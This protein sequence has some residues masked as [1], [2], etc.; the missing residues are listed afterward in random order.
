MAKHFFSVA[1]TEFG[2]GGIRAPESTSVVDHLAMPDKARSRPITL[3]IVCAVA[4]IMAIAAGTSILLFHFRDRALADGERELTNTALIL[5]EQS[6]QVFQ[7]VDMVDKSIIEQMQSRGIISSEDFERQM[8]GQDMHLMLKDKISGLP[9][10]ASVSLFNSEGN[11]INFSR[12]WPIPALNVADQDHFKALK[13]DAH[14][15]SV[16]SAPVLNQTTRTWHVYLARKITGPNGEFLGAV[17]GGLELKYFENFFGSIALGA[18]SAIALFRRDGVLLVRHPR[19]EAPGTSFA[20]GELFKNV[21]SHSDHGVVRLTSPIDGEERL[22]AGYVLAHYPVVVAVGK[23]VTAALAD[24][25]HEA[26]L[27]IGAGT[28][29]AFVILVFSFLI[30]RRLLRRDKQFKEW[31]GEQK[32]MLDTAL[33]NMSQGVLMFDSTARLVLCNQR[34]IEMH[35]LSPEVVKPGCTLIDIINHRKATGSFAGDPQQYFS[36][37]LGKIAEGKRTSRSIE[38]K[39]GRT[40]H[41][42]VEPMTNGWWISTHEDIT[43]R[44]RAEIER[45]RIQK[46]LNTI[47]ENVPAPIFVKEANERR[48]VLVNRA[49]ENFWGASRA[50][51]IGKTS[52]EVFPK[53][54]ADLITARDE[55]LLRSDQPLFEERQILTPRNGIR[56]IVSKRLVVCDDDGTSRYVVG[57]IEDV[58]ERKR[59]EQELDETRR[60]LNSIIENIPVAVV[61]KDAMTHQYVLVNRAFETMLDLSRRDLLGKTVF[62]IHRTKDA[63]LIDRVDSESLLDN[64]GVY[65]QEIEVETPMRGSRVQATSRFVI[66]DIQGDARYLIAVI[67]DVTER[68]KSEQR[69]AFMAHHDAL[70]GLDNRVAVAKK[71]EEAAARLRRWG[72]HFAVLLLDLDHF[73]DVNDTLGHSA[74]DELLREVATRL[75]ACLRETDVLARLG[76]DEF[77][78]I[79]AGETDQRQATSTLADRITDI[80]AKPFNINGT[81]VHIAVSIGIALAPDHAI[82]TDNLLKM[83]DMALYSAKSAGRN[84]YRFYGTEMSVAASERQGLESDL[85]RAIAQDELELHYQPI[86]DT[87]TRKICGAEALIRWRH[88]TKGMILPDQFIPLAEET[89]LI[90]QIG[91]WVLLTA[92]IEAATWPA[93][94]KVSVNVS[95]VQLRKSNLPDVVMYALAQSGLPPE[96]LELEITETALIESAADCLPALRQ[97][98]NLGIAI[99][100]DDFGTGYSSLSQLTM[101]PFDKIK[102]DKSFTQNLTRRAECAAIIS[103]TLTLAQSLDIATTAEGVET[104]QQYQLLRLA[105]VTSMQGYLFKRPTLATEIDFDSVYSAPGL[106]D[107]A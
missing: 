105:G 88:P 13:L 79:Q 41:I 89:G 21:L 67:E 64:A 37:V 95:P 9:Y 81:D 84:G 100:L 104:V 17:S 42:V 73:K 43:D 2:E 94:V 77:A 68:K 60:F 66:R 3:P 54:E 32:V 20:K 11:L 50:E 97:F 99:A 93:G 38:T 7:A 78:I 48:Y 87:K 26:K 59:A 75:K 58:T 19:R 25:Q 57:V 34:Y 16:V 8:S 4:L 56:S 71:I 83:A 40:V 12:F 29:A 27:L 44:R 36:E 98:K 65:C 31:L 52:H 106:E 70:T 92:C 22:I 91:E 10:V 53:K 90:V 35:D 55:E 1:Q 46:F 107:A 45:D 23:T 101:F 69:I 5:A 76:G 14:L 24:W 82:D 49:G 102:I 15:T 74:G 39:D 51:M 61:V 18:D 33:N 6:D 30:A 63:E 72:E 103:A 96:R 28:L 62:D 80:I 85:R 86:I 47:I